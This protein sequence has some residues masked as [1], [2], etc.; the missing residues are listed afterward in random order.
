MESIQ[1]AKI[2]TNTNIGIGV[3]LILAPFIL[4]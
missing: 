3:W 1:S 4:G 2:A